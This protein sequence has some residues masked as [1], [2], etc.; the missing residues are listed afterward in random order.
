[1]CYTGGPRCSNH[2]KTKLSESAVELRTK[3]EAL[4][5][6]AVDLERAESAV[7]AL[8]ADIGLI[9]SLSVRGTHTRAK[10][11]Q[12]AAQKELEQAESDHRQAKTEY[13]LTPEGINEVRAMGHTDKADQLVAKRKQ[14]VAAAKKRQAAKA[15]GGASEP[16][17]ET[18]PVLGYKRLHH[19]APGP[20]DGTAPIHDLTDLYGS[21]YIE[22]PHH[23]TGTSP[24]DKEMLS[25]VKKARGNPDA[26][27]TIYRALPKQH[28]AINDGDW[29][30][31]SKEYAQSHLTSISADPNAGE[32]HIIAHKVPA[33]TLWSE[34]NDLAEWGYNGEPL[35]GSVL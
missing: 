24:H 29:V 3:Q 17:D 32:W 14:L 26:M 6:T 18:K 7:Q 16:A 25:Q 30:A 2:A 31:L 1:M 13:A 21:D 5:A 34:G 35:K 9:A 11:A 8:P 10:R 27:L 23:Y 22:N 15:E 28:S 33:H 4:D 19:L 12:R 20:G